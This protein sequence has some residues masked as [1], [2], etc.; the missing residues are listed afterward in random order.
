MDRF[1]QVYDQNR[2]GL[3]TLA[4]SVTGCPSQAE[5]AIQEAFLRI[6]SNGYASVADPVAY[7]FSA[8]RRAA[9][10][11]RRRHRPST[12]PPTS[13]Y[14]HHDPST[15]LVLDDERQRLAAAVDTLPPEERE[16][17]V[18]RI[19]G[20]LGF[21]QIAEVCE[22]ALSTAAERFQRGLARLRQKLGD[23][24]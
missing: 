21:A 13:I 15:A 17:V 6:F 4:L 16:A 7:A 9:I 3:Y 23:S 22:C 2:Q 1:T 8:V 5:D 10:D 12:S 11:Q 19:H 18:L 24:P 14:V 20:Q